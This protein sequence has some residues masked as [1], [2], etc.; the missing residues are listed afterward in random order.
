MAKRYYFDLPECPSMVLALAERL[1]TYVVDITYKAEFL[2]DPQTAINRVILSDID[3]GEGISV[4]DSVDRFRRTDA[5][6]PFTAYN[7]NDKDLLT[8]MMSHSA[9]SGAE[10]VEEVESF[11]RTWPM[12]LEFPMVSF[13]SRA[14]DF[15]IARTNWEDQAHSLV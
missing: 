3:A 11:V 14:D 13:F 4:G 8:D 15:E 1:I 7:I 9:K 10:F 5:K 6:F 2:I 12:E